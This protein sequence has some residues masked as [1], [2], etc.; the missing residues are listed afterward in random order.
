MHRWFASCVFAARKLAELLRSNMVRAVY[1]GEHGVRTLRELAR[2]YLT[3]STDLI[4]VMAR[5]AGTICRIIAVQSLSNEPTGRSTLVLFCNGGWSFS[6]RTKA[7]LRGPIRDL[8]AN[9]FTSGH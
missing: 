1:H 8:R 4:Q 7:L 6:A 3:I 5:V 2:S 9:A